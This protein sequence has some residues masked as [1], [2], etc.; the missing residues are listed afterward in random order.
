MIDLEVKL[1][2]FVM[3]IGGNFSGCFT[4]KLIKRFMTKLFKRF[5][6]KVV[7]WLLPRAVT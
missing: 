3:L 7:E 4:T 1:F 5:M 6:T 2:G